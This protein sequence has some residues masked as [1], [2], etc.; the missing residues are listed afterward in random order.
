MENWLILGAE[1]TG[2]TA[3]KSSG[4]G[5]MSMLILMAVLFFIMYWLMIRPQKKAEE[6]RRQMID[7]LG[8]GDRVVT[9]GGICGA[10]VEI[11]G[12]FVTLKV[13]QSKNVEL[14]FLKEAI[15]GVE[16]KKDGDDSDKKDTESSS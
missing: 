2:E 4:S 12:K 6:K 13:D 14:K 15:R 9:V 8:K 11:D 5:L 3:G 10:V 16:H 1:A 7:A